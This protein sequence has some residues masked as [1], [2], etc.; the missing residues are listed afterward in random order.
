[1]LVTDAAWGRSDDGVT[2]MSS[3]Y[4]GPVGIEASVVPRNRNGTATGSDRVLKAST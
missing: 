2:S 1:M 4:C 3:A